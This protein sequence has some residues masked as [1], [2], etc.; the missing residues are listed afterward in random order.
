ME[1]SGDL[2]EAGVQKKLQPTAL[3]CFLNTAACYLKME[4][5]Q[6]AQDSCNEVQLLTGGSLEQRGEFP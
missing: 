3:S 2:L 4:Q 6:D 1:V 5:W